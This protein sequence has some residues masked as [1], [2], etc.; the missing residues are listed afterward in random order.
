M[1]TENTNPINITQLFIA[2]HTTRQ[3]AAT[4]LEGKN[5]SKILIDA[6]KQS[7]QFIADLIS[8]L[9]NY[10]DA[11]ASTADRNNPY[12]ILWINNLDKIEHLDEASSSNLFAEMELLLKNEYHLTLKGEL[13]LPESLAQILTKQNETISN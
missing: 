2:L 7:T 1:Q 4:R 3:E 12:Q 11:V 13:D 6:N 9:S 8:E 10:G 5:L